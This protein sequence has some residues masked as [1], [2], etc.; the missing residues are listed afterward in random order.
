MKPD[1]QQLLMNDSLLGVVIESPLEGKIAQLYSIYRLVLL[2]QSKYPPHRR[3]TAILP[4]RRIV[5]NLFCDE[6]G[7]DTAHF[8]LNYN[9]SINQ[10]ITNVDWCDYRDSSVLFIRVSYITY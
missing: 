6:Y 2:F 5:C 9:Q 4:I 3:S 1:F 7:R 8:A 10:S